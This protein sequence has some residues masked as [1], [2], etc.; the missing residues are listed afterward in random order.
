MS[1]GVIKD[2]DDKQAKLEELQQERKRVRDEVYSLGVRLNAGESEVRA[3][4]DAAIR[5]S[6]ELA[7]EISRLSEPPWAIGDGPPIAA[8]MYGPPP[9]RSRLFGFLSRLLRRS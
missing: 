8:P 5:R 9:I 7:E 6:D 1:P 4:L 3:A 2:M